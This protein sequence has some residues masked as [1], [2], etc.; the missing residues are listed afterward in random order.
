MRLLIPQ[1]HRHFQH[2]FDDN[3]LYSTMFIPVQM[4][5]SY[6]CRGLFLSN[7]IEAK[8][9]KAFMAALIDGHERPFRTENIFVTNLSSALLESL[10]AT[11][12]LKKIIPRLSAY[13]YL[14]LAIGQDS[15][16]LREAK[17]TLLLHQ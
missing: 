11:P 14:C 13:Q 4:A 5:N 17:A 2:E 7:E 15:S 3:N 16:V 10:F 12:Q 1:F 8:H 6:Y 9:Q